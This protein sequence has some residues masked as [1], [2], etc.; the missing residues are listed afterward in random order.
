MS[1]DNLG[2]RDDLE[3]LQRKAV[4]YNGV[5]ISAFASATKYTPGAASCQNLSMVF[6]ESCCVRG[7]DL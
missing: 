6:Y 2:L 5:I 1:F 3:G 4:I 7:W